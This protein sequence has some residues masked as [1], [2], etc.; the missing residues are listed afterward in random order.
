MEVM[1]AIETRR[2]IRKYKADPIPT[3]VLNQCLEAIRLAPSGS[4]RQPWRFVVVVDH[5]VRQQLQR[6]EE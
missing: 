3:E 6:I 2:S 5:E 4:N 1:T